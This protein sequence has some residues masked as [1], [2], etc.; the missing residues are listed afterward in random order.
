V[1]IIKIEKMESG[2]HSNQTINR[3]SKIPEGWAVIPEDMVTE[4]FPFGDLTAEEI[5]GVMTVTSWTPGEIPEPK[6]LPEPEP[7]TDDVLNTLLGVIE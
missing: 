3:L 2:A 6:P 5:D 1:R 7:S 4:N